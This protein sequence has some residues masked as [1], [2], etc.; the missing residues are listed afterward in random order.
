MM[1][2]IKFSLDRY[3]EGITFKNKLY[4][5]VRSYYPDE[6]EIE[7]WSGCKVLVTGLSMVLILKMVNLY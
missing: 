7:E 1:D 3:R 5:E 6:F 4:W 2:H